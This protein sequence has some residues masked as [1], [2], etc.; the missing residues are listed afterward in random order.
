VF[1]TGRVTDAADIT[2]ERPCHSSLCV[3]KAVYVTWPGLSFFIFK[4]EGLEKMNFRSTV[5]LIAHN[6]IYI[7]AA[8]MSIF[9]S[10]DVN[11]CTRNLVVSEYNSI[12]KC[13][14]IDNVFKRKE[15]EV[16]KT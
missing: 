16:K 3:M 7:I 13:V 1:Q 11:S 15:V 9:F 8:F 14:L 12:S 4:M 6:F 2:V 5:V 10:V